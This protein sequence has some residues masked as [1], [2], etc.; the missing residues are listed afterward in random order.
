[1]K[2]F[3]EIERFERELVDPQ[4]GKDKSRLDELL[5]D[6]FLEFGSSGG[7]IGKADVLAAANKAGSTTYELSE[8]AC[9]MLG[10]KHVLVTYRSV[11][12]SKVFAHRS[13]IWVEENGRWQMLHHQST[14]V[15]N[16]AVD[17]AV[18]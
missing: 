17:G 12:S 10:D 7:V 16:E 2:V 13:S 14:I 6:D 5:S 1:M 15:R 8:F 9:K 18:S 4:W 3:Q 11:T